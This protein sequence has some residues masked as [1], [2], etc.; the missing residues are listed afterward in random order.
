MVNAKEYYRRDEFMKGRKPRPTNMKKLEG[1]RTDRI[2]QNEPQPKRGK[3]KCPRWLMPEAKKEW[4]RIAGELEALRL[5]TEIDRAAFIGYCQSWAK[6][7]RAEKLLR[8]DGPLVTN[9][10]GNLVANPA[11]WISSNSLKHMLKFAAEFGLTP[12]SRGRIS[13][14]QEKPEDPLDKL[15]NTRRDN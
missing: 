15:L 7:L 6:Y 14:P 11:M 2:N 8:E 1:C 12:S 5:L 9:E 3:V 10:K 4:K 13:I